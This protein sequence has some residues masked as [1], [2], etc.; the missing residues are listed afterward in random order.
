MIKI[1]THKK[2]WRPQIFYALLFMIATL[3]NGCKKD[4]NLE[5]E[6]LKAPD[7]SEAQA[8]YEKNFPV[9]N[10]AKVLLSKG[11]IKGPIDFSQLIKPDWNRSLSYNRLQKGVIEIPLTE[12]S[13]MNSVFKNSL[14]GKTFGKKEFSRSSFVLLKSEGSYKAFVMTIIADSSYVKGDLKKLSHNTYQKHD[15]D[16]SGLVLYFTPKG[17]F[18][19]AYQYKNGKLVKTPT[20]GQVTDKTSNSQKKVL[21]NEVCIDWYLVTYIDNVEVSEEYLFTTCSGG[22]DGGGGGGGGSPTPPNPC[23]GGVAPSS[24]SAKGNLKYD[25]EQDPGDGGFPLPS[26]DPNPCNP[27][28]GGSGPGPGTPR[29]PDFGLDDPNDC[30]NCRVGDE[31]FDDL[32]D[33]A[34]SIGLNVQNPFNTTLTVNGVNYSGQITQITNAAGEVVGAYFSPDSNGGPF[35][36]GVEYSIGNGSNNNPGSPPSS[37]NGGVNFGNVSPSVGSPGSSITYTPPGGGGSSYIPGQR[38]AQE[39]ADNNRILDMLQQEDTQADAGL[40]PCHGTNRSGNV[41]WNGTLEHWL[42]QMDYMSA[43]AGAYKE[44]FVPGSS[45]QQNGRPGYADIANTSSSEMFEIKPDNNAG[46]AAGS[47]EVQIYVDQANLLCPS[48]NGIPWHAGTNY[49]TRNLIDPRNPANMI[50]ARLYNNG[51]IVYASEPKNGSPVPSPV[52]LPQNLADKLKAL[53]R[54]IATASPVVM[55]QQIL[56]FLRANP[57]IV[58]YLKGA[59]AVII[60]GT[61]IEDIVTE[62]VG[63]ADDWQSFLVARTLW[64]VS[65]EIVLF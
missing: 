30:L 33:Y 54:Q 14:N 31:N 8:W 37:N 49:S 53:L 9:S 13:K 46:R 29:M 62:G 32:L 25:T 39:M 26:D 36:T 19:R 2:R 28:G 63:V 5:S 55:Q 27:G 35:Q 21:M 4:D 41:K 23:P 43:N 6:K 20:S 59:A 57:R 58:P 60:I 34:E 48:A 1:S 50:V 64:R 7:I 16:F 52:V 44:Y 40:N 24:L 11:K 47:A 45:S 15:A 38:E 51:V 65:N 22:D 42:I 10:T 3:V 18:L 61:I 17:K 12:D 56:T